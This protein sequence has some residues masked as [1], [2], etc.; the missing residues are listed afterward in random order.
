M[1]IMTNNIKTSS[2]QLLFTILIFTTLITLSACGGGIDNT[3]EDSNTEIIANRNAFVE[4]ETTLVINGFL[5]KFEE[6]IQ[7]KLLNE[8]YIAKA[9]RIFNNETTHVKIIINSDN[10]ATIDLTTLFLHEE[11]GD[12]QFNIDVYNANDDS[13]IAWFPGGEEYGNL[14]RVNTNGDWRLSIHKNTDESF[15]FIE[16]NLPLEPMKSE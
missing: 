16:H 13:Y 6:T 10:S 4:Y 8:E 11:E 9:T 15:N 14:I 3:K 5:N 12:Y 1:N 7:K 2:M